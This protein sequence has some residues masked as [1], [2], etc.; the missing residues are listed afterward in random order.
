MTDPYSQ[1]AAALWFLRA[2]HLHRLVRVAEQLALME[3]EAALA[4]QRFPEP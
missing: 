3:F 4:S 1:L 2:E